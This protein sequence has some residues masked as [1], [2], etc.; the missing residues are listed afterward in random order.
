MHNHGPLAL[1]Y[2]IRKHPV[3][4]GRQALVAA[5]AYEYILVRALDPGYVCRGV[6]GLLD[7]LAVEVDR[8]DLSL[9]ERASVAGIERLTTANEK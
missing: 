4:G 6:Y 5:A 1:L 7:I 2:H 9:R 8:R 3:H